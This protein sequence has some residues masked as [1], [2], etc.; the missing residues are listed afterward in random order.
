MRGRFD[1]SLC[2]CLCL[3]AHLDELQNMRLPLGT[4]GWNHS[5]LRTTLSLQL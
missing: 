4:T 1:S 2:L 3:R 5:S